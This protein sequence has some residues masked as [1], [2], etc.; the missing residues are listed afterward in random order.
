[1]K[2]T[3]GRETLVF[4]DGVR[5]T[6]FSEKGFWVDNNLNTVVDGFGYHKENAKVGA[7][8]MILKGYI[9][10]DIE[11]NKRLLNRICDPSVAFCRIYDGNY[12]LEGRLYK[13]IEYSE[14]KNDKLKLLAFTAEFFCPDP[15]WKDTEEK[16]ETLYSCG[17][18]SSGQEPL[19]LQNDGDRE[20]GFKL[21]IVLSL[22]CKKIEISC[23]DKKII[24]SGSFSVG[25]NI[26]IDT[27]KGECT[28]NITP[29]NSTAL[30]N[31]MRYVLAGS[32][33]FKLKVGTSSIGYEFNGGAGH[34]VAT[35]T[36]EYL[37]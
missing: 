16:T 28:V 9:E 34:L 15:A 5:L 1:M 4:G 26:Y 22:S 37:R 18:T 21:R 12:V 36:Q 32:E 33:F 27:R 14:R 24:L 19:V 11:A 23:D 8:R 13:G 20:V 30:S 3:N 31:G 29:V 7:K 2:I 17:S 6:S 25:Q 10:K 35:Y